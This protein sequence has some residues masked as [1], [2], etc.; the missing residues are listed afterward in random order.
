[1]RKVDPSEME[2][3]LGPA[4]VSRPLSDALGTTDLAINYYELAPGDST[5]Y[6]MHAHS[7]QE[8][9]FYVL[10]GQVTF[11]TREEPVTATAGEA[12]RVGR[13]EYQR[14]RNDGD[15]RA[16]VLALGAPRD[17]GETEILRDCPDCGDP[18]P[19][20]LSM[21]DD[22]TAVLAACTVCGTVTGEFD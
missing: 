10:S 2:T 21:N 4:A 13:G 18:T 14:S 22:R 8:E 20:E 6:G 9:V 1:M 19:Q 5:A 17:G 12:V 15:E 7:D 3:R 11:E 16:V